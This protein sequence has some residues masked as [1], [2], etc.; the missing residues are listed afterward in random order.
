MENKQKAV[1]EL[2]EES[3]KF[4]NEYRRYGA[5]AEKIQKAINFLMKYVGMHIEIDYKVY[6]KTI[7]DERYK[8]MV[9]TLG[10]GRTYYHNIAI[11]NLEKSIKIN[12]E[13]NKMLGL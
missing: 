3:K 5:Y 9:K 7:A 10:D 4:Y 8:R 1:I 2:M 6:Y 11:K 13:I 12:E